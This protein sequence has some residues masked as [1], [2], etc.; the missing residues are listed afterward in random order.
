MR[1][2]PCDAGVG[3]RVLGFGFNAGGLFLGKLTSYRDL[4][5]WQAAMDLVEEV[6]RLSKR[7]PD[8]ERF[9]LVSQIRRA[10][11]SI[12]SNIAEGYGRKDRGDYRRHLSTSNGSLKEIE[13]QP[14]IAGR[15]EYIGKDDTRPAWDLC[16]RIGK[17]LHALSASLS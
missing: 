11:V 7:F 17:M 4:D 3:C 13:T 15:L 14:L 1:R 5:V 6:Y 16:Q 8:D 2:S 12:P 9:G 10:V